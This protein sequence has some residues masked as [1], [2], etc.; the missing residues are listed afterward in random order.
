MVRLSVSIGGLK[1]IV[2]L[3]RAR[4][5]RVSSARLR[6]YNGA[7][8]AFRLHS[9]TPPAGKIAVFLPNWVGDVVMA[10]PALEAL[11]RALPAAEITYVGRPAALATVSGTDAADHMVADRSAP[12]RRIAGFLSTAAA[13]RRRRLRFA[14]LL[15][16]SFRVAAL[17]RNGGIGDLL[18][19]DRDGRGLLLTRKRKA[20]RHYDGSFRPVPAIDYYNALI[21]TI[22]VH[23]RS[24]R[25]RL[26]V[27]EADEAAAE[28]LLHEAGADRSRPLVMLNPG[29]AFGPSKMWDAARFAAVADALIAHR[30]AQVII[31][32]A[33]SERRVAAHVARAMRGRPAVNF[34]DR[35]NTLGLLKGLMKRCRLLITNDTGA[36][37]IAA[38]FEIAIVT[39]FGST[40][41]TWARIDYPRERIVRVDVPCSPCQKPLCPQPAG[42]L[43]HRCM[44]AIEPEVVL[45]AAEE[46]LDEPLHASQGVAP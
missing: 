46:L 44:T 14:V 23:C 17:A 26:A 2:R 5:Q 10:T 18:G 35:P 30:R 38:A 37:H 34:A 16:N 31:N 24:R 27:T 41:P 36:R 33:P 22:G 40:D 29:A 12:G 8:M 19:Y 20:P 3:G 25:M 4:Q 9:K 42:P 43:Y 7:P 45:A 39:L 32:A 6:P 21:E 11:R 1:Q 15:P 13:L 28:T